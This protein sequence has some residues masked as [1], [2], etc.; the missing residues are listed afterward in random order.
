[1]T[2]LPQKRSSVFI[3]YSHNDI[4]WLQRLRVHLKPLAREHQIEIWDDSRIAAGSKWL[5]EIT[6][7]L[8]DAKVAVLLVSADYLASDF[9]ASN[10][11]PQL[12]TAA[13]AGGTTILPVVLSPSLFMRTTG[14]SEFQAVNDPSKP[15]IGMPKDEQEAVL[16]RVT[17]AIEAAFDNHSGA[18]VQHTRVQTEAGLASAL[19][20]D[21]PNRSKEPVD[22]GRTVD[23]RRFSKSS[24]L[25]WIGIAGIALAIVAIYLLVETSGGAKYAGKVT[26][27]NSRQPIRGAQVSLETESWPYMTTTESDGAF[28]F[29]LS[30]PDDTGRLTVQAHGY[31]SFDKTVSLK[32]AASSNV[33]LVSVAP[34]PDPIKT[35]DVESNTNVNKS[36]PATVQKPGAKKADDLEKRKQKA[37][38]DLDYEK[39]P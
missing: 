32:D 33:Q 16:V 5:D 20:S 31:E 4:E 38:D 19:R 21:Q 9:I 11:L 14:L 17:E 24:L 6:K 25:I 13:K 1:M 2:D 35:P 39:Q 27:K 22:T 26:D 18:E 29:T 12:L 37:R 15:L 23:R 10:E 30:I 28:Y 34:P 3:S 8:A 7:A 36:G